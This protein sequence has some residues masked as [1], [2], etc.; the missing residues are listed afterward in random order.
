MRSSILL[1]TGLAVFNFSCSKNE[2]VGE[3]DQ[4]VFDPTA[5]FESQI[6]SI[7]NN[8]FTD[9]SLITD[10]SEVMKEVL[11]MAKDSE[12]RTYVY[13]ETKN[14]SDL[15]EDYVVNLDNVA[16]TYSAK[17]GKHS[18]SAA[19]ITTLASKIQSKYP[20]N[21]PM[22][23]FPKSETLEDLVKAN[24]GFDV[25]KN[26]DEPLAVLKGAYN[27][28]YSAPGYKLDTQGKLVFDRMV[29][30][31]Y[32]WNN[33]VYVIGAAENV[34]G[35]AAPCDMMKSGDCYSGGGGTGG[36]SGT[37]SN[38]RVNGRQEYGGRIQV[39]SNLNEIEHWFSGKL[40][41]RM[42][43]SGVQGSVGTVIVDFPFPKVKRKEF[44]DKKWYDYNAFLFNWNLSNLGD[45]NVEKWIERDGGST[46]EVSISIPGSAY[47]PATSTTPAQPA[48]PGT[49]VKVTSKR[50]DDDLGTNIV[51]FSDNLTQVYNLGKMNFKRK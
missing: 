46:T 7:P 51:Q 29:T 42:I 43:V 5:S 19:K 15:G 41:F 13:Q 38:S 39:V 3:L 9:E 22:V 2:E 44:K 45:Y 50:D 12:F 47:K 14:Q 8:E 31:D 37:S 23:F 21:T 32:A 17:N 1:L 16:K 30:E 20:D 18:K 40:E 36:G 26:M 25:A 6:M 27:D 35:F 10:Y 48:F 24:K 28:D 4:N 11:E 34:Q 49:T 33:D